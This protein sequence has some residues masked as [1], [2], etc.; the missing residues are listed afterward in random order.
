M[1]IDCVYILLPD[2]RCIFSKSYKSS[3]ADPQLLGG[4]LSAFN[5]ASRQWLKDP[6]RRF[7]SEGDR[8]F[9][10][11]DFESFLIVLSGIIDTEAEAKMDTISMRFLSKYGG[12]IH[13]WSKGKISMFRDFEKDLDSILGQSTYDQSEQ[14]SSIVDP[15]NTGEKV[16][17]SITIINFPPDFQK[18]ALAL[19][20]VKKGTI[21]TIMKETGRLREIEEPILEDLV[22]Q[23]YIYRRTV[24]SDKIYYIR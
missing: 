13:Q 3:V 21:E 10:I 9:V 6:V 2:G 15:F 16:L 5:I 12:S 8:E 14:T 20:T 24:G 22:Q 17:D 1:E 23:G 11:K 7:V 19:L 18:T 4:L